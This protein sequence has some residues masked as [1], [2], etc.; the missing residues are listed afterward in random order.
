MWMSILLA[1]KLF[2]GWGYTV[3]LPDKAATTNQSPVDSIDLTSITVD[4]KLILTVYAGWEPNFPHHVP[5][6]LAITKHKIGALECQTFSWGEAKKSRETLVNLPQSNKYPPYLHV[7]YT[8]LSPGDAKTADAVIE[9]I[10]ASS[11]GR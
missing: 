2:Q 6:N 8:D 1:V 7:F 5:K 9:S 4:G 3:T 11:K 10:H